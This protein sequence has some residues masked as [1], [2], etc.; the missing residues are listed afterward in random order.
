MEEMK[1]QE[2]SVK[3][4]DADTLNTIYR[5]PVLVYLFEI[6][7]SLGCIIVPLLIWLNIGGIFY[8]KFG[9]IYSL[10]DVLE[11]LKTAAVLLVIFSIVVGIP[12][13]LLFVDC[14]VIM[15][16]VDAFKVTVMSILMAPASYPMVRT[17]ALEEPA[18]KRNFHMVMGTFIFCTNILLVIT[19]VY[20]FL[21][22]LLAFT[23]LH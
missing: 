14:F 3:S 2:Q 16:G 1:N 10:G 4:D 5:N 22:I 11:C 8:P 23:T 17:T 7:N 15:K 9:S 6:T 12:L 18:S 13:L 19:I 21:R 20:Y